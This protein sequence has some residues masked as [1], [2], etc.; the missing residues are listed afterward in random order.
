MIPMRKKI[1]DKM[2]PRT[3]AK[4]YLKNLLMS[5]LF[6]GL[7]VKFQKGFRRKMDKKIPALLPMG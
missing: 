7:T 5:F 2:D 6:Y 4:K 1:E 3:T